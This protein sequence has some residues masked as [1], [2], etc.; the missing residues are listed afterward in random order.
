MKNQG[1]STSNSWQ[2]FDL[3]FKVTNT[4]VSVYI[5]YFSLDEKIPTVKAKNLYVFANECN[6]QLTMGRIVVRD[7]KREHDHTSEKLLQFEY[8][9][10]FTGIDI[11]QYSNMVIRLMNVAVHAYKTYGYGIYRILNRKNR[12]ENYGSNPG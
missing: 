11:S 7:Q 6:R 12:K 2:E 1:Q 5:S 8:S 3:F 10:I 4:K 9:L